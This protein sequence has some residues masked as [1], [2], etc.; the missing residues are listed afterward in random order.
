MSSDLS[1]MIQQGIF[2]TEKLTNDTIEKDYNEGVN[3]ALTVVLHYLQSGTDLY[4]LQVVC[5]KMVANYFEI[6]DNLPK[7][8]IYSSEYKGII[9]GYYNFCEILK[10]KLSKNE[11]G[12]FRQE[13]L[14]PVR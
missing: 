12:L 1:S 2:D 13:I 4:Y 5:E 14:Q 7:D 6:F 10:E 11:V 9:A 8:C 3:K